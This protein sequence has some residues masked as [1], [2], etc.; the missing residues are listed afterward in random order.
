MTHKMSSELYAGL[1]LAFERATREFLMTNRLWAPIAYG[2]PTDNRSRDAR[3][4]S[5]SLRAAQ[6][7][8]PK[9]RL[10]RP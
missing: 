5:A 1:I 4:M 6:V 10:A 2:P 3:S 7:P 9:A 8:L